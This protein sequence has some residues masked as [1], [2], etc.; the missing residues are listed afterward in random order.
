MHYHCDL[1]YGTLMT[2]VRGVVVGDGDGDGD[3]DVVAVV[4]DV[5]N[6]VDDVDLN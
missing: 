6:D 4:N 2:A 5:V 3:G 1:C